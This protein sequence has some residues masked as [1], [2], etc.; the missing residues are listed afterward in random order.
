[1]CLYTS[2]FTDQLYVHTSSQTISNPPLTDSSYAR[3]LYIVPKVADLIK[4]HVRSCP[5]WLG[6]HRGIGDISGGLTLLHA[7]PTRLNMPFYLLTR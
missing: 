5:P 3:G 6:L 4:L 2:A 7:S 1:M